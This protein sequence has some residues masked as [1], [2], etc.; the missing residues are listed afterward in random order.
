M[1]TAGPVLYTVYTIGRVMFQTAFEFWLYA[2]IVLATFFILAYY[3]RKDI[4]NS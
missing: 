4:N 1:Y 2:A 3:T